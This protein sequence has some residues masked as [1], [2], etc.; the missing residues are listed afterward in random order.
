MIDWL[1]VAK[2]GVLGGWLVEIP[3]LHTQRDIRCI[4]FYIRKE[5]F[6]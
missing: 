3:Q 1:K 5:Q 2:H 6:E 4:P